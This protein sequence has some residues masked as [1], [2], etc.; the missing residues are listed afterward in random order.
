MPRRRPALATSPSARIVQRILKEVTSTF[1]VKAKVP[2]AS[3]L[4]SPIVR[5]GDK[6]QP[7]ALGRRALKYCADATAHSLLDCGTCLFIFSRVRLPELLLSRWCWRK[8]RFASSRTLSAGV[9]M[10]NWPLSITS[11]TPTRLGECCVMW[12]NIGANGWPWWYLVRRL[13]ISS[14]ETSG[15]TGRRTRRRLL[16]PRAWNP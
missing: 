5:A 13:F 14:C 4:S 2:S 16:V 12:P 1:R 7:K 10:R 15:C 11:K 9:S 6:D 3:I 8:S